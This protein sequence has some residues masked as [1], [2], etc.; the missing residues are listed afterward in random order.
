MEPDI[1]ATLTRWREIIDA[2]E[3]LN[4][5]IKTLNEEEDAIERRL[6]DLGERTGLDSFANDVLSVT[7]SQK[8]RARYEPG[9]W[10]EIVKWAADGGHYEIIKRQLSDKPVVAL[11][12]NGVALPDGL[13][14][15]D[16]TDISKRRK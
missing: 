15:E 16:Y 14:I 7:L 2:K 11:L 12:V 5:R 4:A 10:A 8:Q 13:S 6:L 3:E 9:R 1:G